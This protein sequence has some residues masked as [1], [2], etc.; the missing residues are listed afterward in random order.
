MGPVE[1][2][3]PASA[4]LQMRHEEPALSPQSQQ[5]MYC[6][7][8]MNAPDGH[9]MWNYQL[10]QQ[11]PQYQVSDAAAKLHEYEAKARELE[12]VAAQYAAAAREITTAA[13]QARAMSDAQPSQ[14]KPK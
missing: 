4:P 11:Q 10:Q 7:M 13:K 14:Q 8:P 1:S 9:M 3:M 12:L 2:K 5:M 6:F